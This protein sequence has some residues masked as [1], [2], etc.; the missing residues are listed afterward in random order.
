MIVFYCFT[1][2]ELKNNT[3]KY[4]HILGTISIGLH[5]L[6]YY[7]KNEIMLTANRIVM[8]YDVKEKISTKRHAVI[9]QAKVV[10]VFRRRK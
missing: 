2:V 1:G 10:G 8:I 7:D 3:F 6:D 4:S 9:E 5:A